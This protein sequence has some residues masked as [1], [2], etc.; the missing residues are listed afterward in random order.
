MTDKAWND[1]WPWLWA[2]LCA[3]DLTPAQYQQIVDRLKVRV[4]D[5]RGGDCHESTPDDA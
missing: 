4:R 2:R 1:L 5:T 3:L